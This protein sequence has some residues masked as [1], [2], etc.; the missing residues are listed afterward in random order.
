[1]K[2]GDD[3]GAAKNER[4]YLMFNDSGGGGKGKGLVFVKGER[5]FGV[6]FIVLFFFF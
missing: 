2:N 6:R 5:G 4:Q 1:M 3:D